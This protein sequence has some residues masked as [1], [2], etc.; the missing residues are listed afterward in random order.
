VTI[1]NLPPNLAGPTLTFY[2]RIFTEDWTGPD[3]NHPKYDSFD[4][5]INRI[6]DAHTLRHYGKPDVNKGGCG[7]L[8]DLGWQAGTPLDL[9]AYRGQAITIDFATTMRGIDA[10]DCGG[11]TCL[12]SYTYL[13]D[14][15]ITFP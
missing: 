14:V 5:G 15:A 1:P 3:P 2:Y 10:P 4:V 9:S 8:N 6:D 13:D 11:L 12:N 7:S